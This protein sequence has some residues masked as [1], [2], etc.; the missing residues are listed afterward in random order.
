MKR[1]GSFFLVACLVLLAKPGLKLAMD[2]EKSLSEKYEEW[3][4]LVSYIILP[5][6]KEVFFLLT[7]D[8]DRDI[9][10][11][12]FWKQRDP[13]PGTPQNEYQEEHI[14]RFQ[15]ANKHF[16]RGTPREG[17]MT[18]M[19][20]IHILLGPPKSIERFEGVAG[21]HPCQ[22]WYYYGDTAK[23]LPPHFALVFFQR[24]GAG[25]YKLY[26]PASDGPASLLIDTKGVDVTDYESVYNKIRELAPTLAGVSLSLIPG[27]YPFGYQPS[28]QNNIILANIFDFPK[29]DVS[30]AYATHFLR[31]KGIVS[32]EYLTNYVESNAEASLFLDP[33]LETAFVHFAIAPKSVSI[34][35]FASRDQYYCNFRIDVSLRQGETI[36]YQYAKD[37]PLYFPPDRVE[38]IRANGVC[39]QDSFPIIEGKYNLTVLLQ[40]AVGKEFSLFEKEITFNETGEA[41]EILGCVLGYKLEDHPAPTYA[42]F[43]TLGKVLSVDPSRTLSPKEEV[44]LFCSVF[45]VSP[46]LWKEGEIVVHIQGLREKEPASKR[47]SFPLANFSYDARMN[48]AL[49]IAASSFAP[50][51][52]ELSL[53]LR[54]GRG[55]SLARTSSNFIISP[56][57][58]LPHPVILSR[59]LPRR[60]AS[61]Y[62]FSLAHQYERVGNELKA[63]AFFEKA[64]ASNPEEK[65][66]IIDYANFLLK[67]HK[68]DRAAE[69]I[70][71]IGA[72][73]AHRFDYYLIK[74]KALEGR[75]KYG[76]AIQN[77]LEGNKIYNSDTRLLNSLGFCY[78]K[79]GK[80]KEALEALQ[81]SLRLNP[82]QSVIREL[83]ERV[84][85]ELK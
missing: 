23:K 49:S 16:S 56:Q 54:N 30:P 27:Q 84:E 44:A 63:Q 79:T 43:K 78:Y 45:P 67:T 4:K 5:Q 81:A 60:S 47:F 34:D 66:G 58:F 18:D 74:G 80:K 55:E 52:Y 35:Y 83:I 46:E 42:P 62:L 7:N 71:R 51:Y 48:L 10:I 70:E 82:E 20:R 6:E 68:F 24:G 13:T 64:I 72:D 28:P 12:S 11:Q 69:L 76:E 3:L 22:V 39:I 21:I 65:Q 50:D 75:G 73:E 25:E 59:S 19:G 61:L 8:R 85:K 33:A 14:K 36:I 37:F 26:N 15:Y 38:T 2:K 29:H 77:L 32:T 41:P 57:D 1:A 9:F 53:E 31:Y 40:N 17:W